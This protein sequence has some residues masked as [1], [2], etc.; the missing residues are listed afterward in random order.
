MRCNMYV[1]G[2]VSAGV[3]GDGCPWELRYAWD[4]IIPHT[5]ICPLG[6][7]TTRDECRMRV[8]GDLAN[9]YRLVCQE[10]M[11]LTH[12]GPPPP[13]TRISRGT[14]SDRLDSHT[15]LNTTYTNTSLRSGGR[16]GAQN[17][18]RLQSV[19]HGPKRPR[20]EAEANERFVWNLSR[21]NHQCETQVST[22]RFHRQAAWVSCFLP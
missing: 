11:H 17:Q 16:A 20:I 7:T 9:D 18:K 8:H 15:H 13:T 10:P 22:E 19:A 2:T 12:V 6:T 4:W 21:C 14:R 1:Y 3:S 5:I